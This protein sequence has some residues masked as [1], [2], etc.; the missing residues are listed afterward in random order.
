MSAANSAKVAA[1]G[2]FIYSFC[3]DIC[4]EDH[5]HYKQANF[6]PTYSSP[7]KRQGRSLLQPPDRNRAIHLSWFF[8]AEYSLAKRSVL[9]LT[10]PGLDSSSR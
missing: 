9:Q 3:K 5:N 8:Q 10:Y 6:N 4:S 2:A 7:G 1:L